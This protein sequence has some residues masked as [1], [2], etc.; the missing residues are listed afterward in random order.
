MNIH[1]SDA[2]Y[3]RIFSFQ[4]ALMRVFGHFINKTMKKTF[5]TAF[6]IGLFAFE[7]HSQLFEIGL[8]GGLTATSGRTNL[9]EHSYSSP[10]GTLTNSKVTAKPDGMGFGYLGGLYA[11]VNVLGFFVQTEASYAHFVLNQKIED[12]KVFLGSSQVGAYKSESQSQLS[13][14]NVPV[15]FGKTFALKLVRVYLGPNFLFVTQA[16][17]NLKTTVGST[18][19]EREEDLTQDTRRELPNRKVESLIIG[20]EAGVGVQLPK[21]PLGFDLRYSV[22]VITGVYAN[23]DITGFM[24]ITTLTVSYRL[25]KLGL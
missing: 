25:F 18:V 12:G 15:L 19:T 10:N 5:I 13:G 1:G 20:L 17:Q 7:G 3:P 9:P 11:R 24:G 8:R 4:N 21:I 22:P 23:K 2:F 6:V 16:K 14:I